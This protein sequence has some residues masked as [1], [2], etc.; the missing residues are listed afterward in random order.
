[1]KKLERNK[2]KANRDKEVMTM[3]VRLIMKKEKVEKN[4][5]IEDL[6]ETMIIMGR[7]IEEETEEVKV[8]VVTR[9]SSSSQEEG[10]EV[11]TNSSRIEGEIEGVKI[12]MDQEIRIMI[13]CRKKMKMSMEKIQKMS[14]KRLSKLRVRGNRR[15]LMWRSWLR[16]RSGL[17]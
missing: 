6:K 4:N 16:M 1:M 9:V 13:T 11:D 8:E 7:L 3:M 10:E 15:R 12:T 17:Q 5:K 2:G 14:M